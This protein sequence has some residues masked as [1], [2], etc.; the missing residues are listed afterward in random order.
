M[1]FFLLR[2]LLSGHKLCPMSNNNNN[3]NVFTAV[4]TSRIMADGF[5]ALR[6]RI[7][8]TMVDEDGSSM[9]KVID[10]IENGNG[11]WDVA[12]NGRSWGEDLS[13]DDIMGA[14]ACM[15]AWD[16]D[17]VLKATRK[18]LGIKARAV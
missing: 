3:N 18:A 15:G 4:A 6:T 9:V 16:R 2:F 14:V 7:V 5:A 11:G 10:I 8:Q 12:L 1:L 17:P 13:A